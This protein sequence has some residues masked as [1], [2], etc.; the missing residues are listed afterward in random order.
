M[1][2]GSVELPDITTEETKGRPTFA[3]EYKHTEEE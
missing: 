3:S 2:L 1:N